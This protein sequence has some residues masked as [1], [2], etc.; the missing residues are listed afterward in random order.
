MTGID[1]KLR[2]IRKIREILIIFAKYGCNG[3]LFSGD[4]CFRNFGLCNSWN[5]LTP[6]LNYNS[7]GKKIADVL[8]SN[9]FNPA[10]YIISL[11]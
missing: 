5:T 1:R 4:S 6:A 7:K 11:H 8:F 10:G 9:T 2:N 3:S